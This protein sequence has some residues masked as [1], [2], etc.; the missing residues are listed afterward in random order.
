MKQDRL[1][2]LQ[3]SILAVLAPM[4]PPWTLSGGAALVGFHLGHRTT[5][6]L[7]LFWHDRRELDRVP[8]DCRQRLE[9]AGMTVDMVQRAP[10]FARLN[11]SGAGESVVVDLVAEPVAH[12]SEPL[13]VDTPGGPIQVDSAAEIL[14]N[15]LGCVLHRTEL[16]DLIDA[17]ALLAQGHDL[18]QAM[19]AA[20][21]KDGGFSPVILGHLLREFPV[22]RLAARLGTA[23][24]LVV[25][26]ERFAI[27]LAARV[28]AMIRPD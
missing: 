20:A 28:G 27:E 6:D 1:T 9:S 18:E 7:D 21:E 16:R 5:R 2:A 19:S 26:L 24:G 25:E 14:A 15:K 17:Q 12:S 22:A 4:R 23:P 3:R 10:G 13:A 11:V 8:E